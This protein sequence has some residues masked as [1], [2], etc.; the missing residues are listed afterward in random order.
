MKLSIFF[1]FVSLCLV[2]G[3]VLILF[4]HFIDSSFFLT[5]NGI[6]LVWDRLVF[7]MNYVDSLVTGSYSISGQALYD[8]YLYFGYSYMI[9]YDCHKKIYVLTGY[10]GQANIDYFLLNYVDSMDSD[11][12][13]LIL[14]FWDR[15]LTVI[16]KVCFDS[17]FE[18]F[19]YIKTDLDDI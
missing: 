9:V 14:Q 8:T 18:C 12:F 2:E 10:F 6:D 1:K 5:V 15:F 4:E 13:L 19:L 16:R 3:L 17:L 7:Y 11:R